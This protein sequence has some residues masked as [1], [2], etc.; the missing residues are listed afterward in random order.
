MRLLGITTP[1]GRRNSRKSPNGNPK[2]EPA[3]RG[4]LGL[5]ASAF[6]PDEPEALRSHLL[7]RWRNKMPARAARPSFARGFTLIEVVVLSNPEEAT[8]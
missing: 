7:N 2:D 1:L 8:V 4:R 3:A 5:R 6:R